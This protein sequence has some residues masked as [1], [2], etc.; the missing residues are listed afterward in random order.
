MQVHRIG[1]GL[2]SVSLGT[3]RVDLLESLL[4][5]HISAPM[6]KLGAEHTVEAGLDVPTGGLAIYSPSVDPGDGPRVVVP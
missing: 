5:V 1:L 4:A 2:H 6:A 3:V